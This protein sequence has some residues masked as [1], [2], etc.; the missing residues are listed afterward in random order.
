M[1]D[2]TP[3]FRL[4]D[5]V[6]DAWGRDAEEPA[7]DGESYSDWSAKQLLAEIENRNA[8]RDESEHIVLDGKKKSDAVAA[9]EADDEAHSEE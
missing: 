7:A 3:V 9:L 4:G 1:S 2:Q 5:R 6:V 8:N